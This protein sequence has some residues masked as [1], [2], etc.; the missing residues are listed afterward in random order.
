MKDELRAQL[1]ERVASLNVDFQK[2]RVVLTT[3]ISDM[4][5]AYMDRIM[6]VCGFHSDLYIDLQ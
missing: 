2:A 6:K 3:L 1:D 5:G 4:N